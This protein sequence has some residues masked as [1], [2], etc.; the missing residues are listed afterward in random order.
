MLPAQAPEMDSGKLR[1][2]VMGKLA[3]KDYEWLESSAAELRAGPFDPLETFPRLGHFYYAFTENLKGEAACLQ[4]LAQLQ[5]WQFAHPDSVTVQT[6]LG[7]F[8]IHFAWQARGSG[9]ASTVTGD[10]WKVFKER[11]EQA[12]VALYGKGDPAKTMRRV[13]PALDP[14]NVAARIVVA[15]A[16]SDGEALSTAFREGARQFPTYYPIY[17]RVQR[18]LLPR[19]GGQP[20]EGARFAAESADKLGGPNADA[21][22]AVLG[23]EVLNAEQS[24]FF[25]TSGFDI[26][27]MLRG[28]DRL[29]TVRGD[30]WPGFYANR[31]AFVAAASGKNEEARRR[32]G[33]AGPQIFPSAWLSPENLQKARRES[34]FL[35]EV[36]RLAEREARGQLA[37]AQA[38][39]LALTPGRTENAWLLP[40]AKRNG[41]AELY[42]RSPGATD[43]AKPVKACS[44]NQLYELI[45][46]HFAAGNLPQ[47]R[48]YAVEFDRQR[49][50]NLTGKALLYFA[51]AINGRRCR[52]GKGPTGAGGI[53]DKPGKLSDCRGLPQWQDPV[54][55]RDRR[56]E[57]GRVSGSGDHGHGRA[58]VGAGKFRRMPAAFR[59]G[60]WL[61]Q[62]LGIVCHE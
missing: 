18:A 38:G 47:L 34:G 55:R 53:Q 62:L 44:A 31:A 36:E 3:A 42:A 8:Y 4:R 40:F 28:Y 41:Q 39:W 11:I 56:D 49:P 37:E 33:K 46:Y 24:D 27:R 14:A 19:W 6:A 29:A 45:E 17:E 21:F 50:W 52:K 59:G 13:E 26:E 5:E 54:G 22:Y 25:K 2:Q 16:Q 43:P 15:M 1:K 48:E 9:W 35:D 23:E 32:L 7:E 20:G 57:G 60:E 10:G 12:K 51:A 58:R 61:L 30:H